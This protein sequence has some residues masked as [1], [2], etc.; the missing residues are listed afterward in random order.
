MHHKSYG[1]GLTAVNEKRKRIYRLL[2]HLIIFLHRWFC[3]ILYVMLRFQILE[4]FPSPI[5]FHILDIFH[6]LFFN[7][8]FYMI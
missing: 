1:S 4:K 7:K 3:N 5:N 6:I 2:A 8:Y